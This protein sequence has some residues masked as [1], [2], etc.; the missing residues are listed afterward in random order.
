MFNSAVNN[1]EALSENEIKI[2]FAIKSLLIKLIIVYIFCA[3]YLFKK[4]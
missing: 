4:I 2:Y 1:S 3:I